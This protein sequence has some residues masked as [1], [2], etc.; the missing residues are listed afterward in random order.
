MKKTLLIAGL[1]FASVF[2]VSSV[3]A[4]DTGEKKAVD[5]KNIAE[6]GDGIHRVQT[7][8]DGALKSFVAVGS[9]K[10]SRA[11]GVVKGKKTAQK[12]ARLQAKAEIVKWLKG[13]VKSY[14][15][16]EDETI[17]IMVGDDNNRSETGKSSEKS[18]T[19]IE[20]I[21][22][23]LVRGTTVIYSA[24]QTIN[25]EQEYIVILGWSAKNAKM[26][27]RARR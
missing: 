6:L 24:I 13:H 17:T 23:G 8:E 9:A 14:E 1:V 3:N 22:E 10:I 5:W 11:L 26:A 18:V 21:A 7:D 12:R 4:E 2:G 19:N 15:I 27:K 20:E 16:S 25:D